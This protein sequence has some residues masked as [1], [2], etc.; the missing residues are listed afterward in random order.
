[1]NF[2][3]TG[4]T[5][6]IPSESIKFDYKKACILAQML[7]NKFDNEPTIVLDGRPFAS[8]VG[9]ELVKIFNFKSWACYEK[10]IVPE[11][12]YYKGNIVT[13]WKFSESTKEGRELNK[14]HRVFR[15]AYKRQSVLELSKLKYKHSSNN[16]QK[17]VDF[18]D[19]LIIFGSK[20]QRV[21]ELK[22]LDM[23]MNIIKEGQMK[24]FSGY[25]LEQELSRVDT[26]MSLEEWTILRKKGLSGDD[27]RGYIRTK[28]IIKKR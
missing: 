10:K 17:I 28:D 2:Y 25:P 15:K 12:V 19:H 3:I 11:K 8:Y 24:W 1:M 13:V 18:A 27:V 4:P 20:E 14:H 16:L 7:I 6:E 23:E 5:G 22:T 9:Y 21:Q 26:N